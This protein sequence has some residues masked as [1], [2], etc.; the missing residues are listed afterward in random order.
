MYA[1]TLYNLGELNEAKN[2][3][4]KAVSAAEIVFGPV[5]QNTVDYSIGY[6]TVLTHLKSYESSIAI[7]EKLR[8]KG[9]KNQ[10]ILNNIGLNY[11]H[12]RKYKRAI[13]FFKLGFELDKNTLGQFLNNV[14]M[15]HAKAGNLSEAHSCFEQFQA[16]NPNIGQPYRNWAMY[17]AILADY[18]KALENLEK[19][20]QL[21]YYNLDWLETEESLEPLRTNPRFWDIIQQIKDK[22]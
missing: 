6:A 19:A 3:Y 13:D 14:G 20:V 4:E 16:L 11:Y 17:F 15:A 8:T 18:P 10:V 12:L 5:H 9:V 1:L 22:K 7:L 21:G 2:V